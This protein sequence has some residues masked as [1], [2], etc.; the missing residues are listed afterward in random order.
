MLK[1]EKLLVFLTLIVSVLVGGL[2]VV[3]QD[4][5][6]VDGGTL[7]YAY[8][9]NPRNFN[10]LDAVQGVQSEILRFT[11]NSLIQYDIGF[12]TDAIPALAE[13]WEVSDDARTFTF[14]LR[15]DVTWHDGEPFTA[16]DVVFTLTI[17]VHPDNPTFWGNSLQTLEGIDA[18]IAGDADSISGLVAMDDYTVSITTSEPSVVMLDTLSFIGMLPEHALS[19]IA[20][21]DLKDDPFFLNSPIGTGP[22]MVVEV[23]EDQFVRFERNENYFRGAPHLDGINL[24][25]PDASTVPAGLE[26]GEIDLSRDVGA[27]DLERFLDNPDFQ[28]F[29]QPGNVFCNISANTARVPKKVRQAIS[30][31][32]DR[33]AI[34]D[35]LYLGSQLS[36][37]FY[38]HLGHEF[39]QPNSFELDYSFNADT[40]M[41]LIAE[42]VADGDWEEGRVLNYVFSG[43]EPGNDMLFVSQFLA[44]VGITVEL[45]GAGDRGAF[46]ERVLTEMD[47]DLVSICNGYGPDPDSVSIYYTSGFTFSEGGFNFT[48][49]SNPRVDEILSLGRSET[50]RDARILLYQELQGILDDEAVMIPIR[51]GNNAWVATSQLRDATPQYYGHLAN[52]NGVENWWLEPVD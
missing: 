46:N 7:N 49:L 34:T 9:Q 48:G 20:Y 12:F 51:L 5:T 11:Y 33:Q 14:N 18:F 30:F 36:A 16:D 15:D 38:H 44:D 4:D 3:A 32:I 35:E 1:R 31:A 40:A 25:I 47:Y 8:S 41:S 22:F 37:P 6:P 13:S 2:M 27:D 17:A 21:A 50:D 28:I 10:P 23:A 52:Y 45:Q 43:E 29:W 26:T 42:A 39:L 24:L 19:D